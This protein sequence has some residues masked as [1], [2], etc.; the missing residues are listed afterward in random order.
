M[1]RDAAAYG[2]RSEEEVDDLFSKA[3]VTGPLPISEISCSMSRG[4]PAN[5]PLKTDGRYIP[6][7]TAKT[8]GA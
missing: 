6:P 5:M 4:A 7:L 8:S 3:R 1:R 2:L